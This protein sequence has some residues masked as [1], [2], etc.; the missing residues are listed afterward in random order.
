MYWSLKT[1]NV[2]ESE[3]TGEVSKRM[4]PE[5]RRVMVKEKGVVLKRVRVRSELG[6]ER[7]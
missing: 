6:E 1:R 4:S 7:M 5:E 2:P 3:I